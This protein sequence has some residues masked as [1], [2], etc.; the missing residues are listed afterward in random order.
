M[1]SGDRTVRVFVSY[2]HVDAVW[3][4]RLTPLLKGIRGAHVKAWTD[5][6]IRP[7]ASW[8]KEIKAALEAMDVFIAL[9][10]VNF[11]TSDYIR[12]VE[13]PRA[14][15]RLTAKEIHVLPVYLGAP[16]DGD[17]KWLM[18]LQRVPGEESWSEMRAAFPDYDHALKPIRDGIKAVVERARVHKAGKR[19]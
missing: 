5:K 17:C 11:G 15:A 3:L 9:V 1:P 12:K 16:S 18:N 6:D 4:Q 10:S 14:K 19:P 2:S 8:D 13:L 7:G